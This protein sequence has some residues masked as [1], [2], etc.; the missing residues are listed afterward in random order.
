MKRSNFV[1]LLIVVSLALILG[2]AGGRILN[3][4]NQIYRVCYS[5]AG[6]QVT[7]ADFFKNADEKAIFA[8]N[9]EPFDISVPGEYQIRL[10]SGGLSLKSILIIEDTIAPKGEAVTVNR[11]LGYESIPADF[12]TEIRDAT[13]VTVSFVEVPDFNLAGRQ[14]VTIRLTDAG[15]NQ[16]I[17]SSVLILSAAVSSVTIE[18]GDPLPELDDFVIVAE[19]ADFHTD[20]SRI[21]SSIPGDYVIYL[22]LDGGIFESILHIIDTIPPV[23]TVKDV[24]G[25]N[26]LPR[27]A[28]E[29]VV[30]YEDNSPVTFS[31]LT[32]PDLTLVGTQEVNI[33][34]R[35]SGG[36]ETM[37]S[38]LLTLEA[39]TEPPVIKGAVDFAVQAGD[40]V[41]YMRNVAATDNNPRG[42]EFTVDQSA[43]NINVA[44][45]YPV[46]YIA[47]DFAGN[48]T[49][50]TVT[51]TVL[52]KI[53]DLDKIY[54]K[55]DEVIA[56]IITAEMTEREKLWAIYRYNMNNIFFEATWEKGTWVQAAY[57]GLIDR[58]GDCYV[59][60]M[61]AKVLLDRAG[62][63]NEDIE[64]IVTSSRHYWHLVDL[65][66]G[67]YHFDTTPRSDKVTIFMWTNQQLEELMQET[68]YNSHRYDPDIYPR[69]RRPVN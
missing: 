51:L 66:D 15:G 58:R 33:I 25:Y 1:A 9:S 44:G 65:G 17:L 8:A 63:K 43:V 59:Y 56:R 31:F 52:P 64:K 68:R 69:D 19:M 49:T 5:E 29:F 57:E 46:T 21:D 13:A 28:A 26:L 41:A 36:N 23:F 20:L 10:R 55:A 45:T 54:Q 37:Q 30:T 60:A 16:T 18:A 40:T 3:Q 7:P 48:E 24:T 14:N 61:T 32:D 67:W 39:D 62:I 2:L 12:V 35:D 4:Y 6:V 47:R 42:L 53:Y 22:R 34:A 11:V 38:A 50:K 27:E